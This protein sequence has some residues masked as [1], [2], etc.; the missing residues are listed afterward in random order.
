MAYDL[1]VLGSGTGGYPSA[2]RASQLG[3]KV[4]IIEK[5]NLGGVCLNWGCIPT[6]ALLKSAQVFQDIL[7]A[8]EFGIEASGTVDFPAVITRSR[9]VADKMS[10]GV[11]FLMR[12]NKIDVVKGYG[13]L[14]AKGQVEVTGADG[15]TQ[16]VEGKHIIVATGARS[17]ELPNLK[18]DGKKVIGYREAMTLPQKPKSIIVVGSGAIG[19]EFA[20]FYYSMG[21][22]VTVV[23]FL[24]RIVPLEDEEISREL[25]KN[26]KKYGIDILLNSE[27]TSV[28]TSGDGVKAKVKTPTGEVTLEADILLSAIGISANIENIGLETLGVKTDKGK[29]LVDKFYQTNIPGIYAVGDCVPGQALA[30]VSTKE[31]I[32]CVENIAYMEKKFAHQPEALDYGNVPGCTYCTPEIASVGLTEKQA[33]DAGYEIKVGKF[34]LTAS[35]KATGVSHTEGFVKVIFDAKYG[36]WLGTHMIGYNVTE[37]IVETVVGRKLET[38][39]HEVLDSIHPHPTISESVKD[40]IEQAYGEAIHL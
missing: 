1:V 22:K 12:K 14:K 10:K 38:T 32:I 3:F 6:K 29:I 15:N 20:Y 36:E 5:E 2:I 25:E 18:Q 9:G 11:Q 26:Y 27:V 30:H 24:P 35:G 8:K 4:A 19:V 16:L 39:Y 21:T 31:A 13:K 40:T 34:P 28:D 17:R 7:H 37:I 33:R 23:E